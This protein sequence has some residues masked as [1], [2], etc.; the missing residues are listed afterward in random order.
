MTSTCSLLCDDRGLTDSRMGVGI[1]VKRR[2]GHHS[3]RVLQK[4]TTLEGGGRSLGLCSMNLRHL[5]DSYEVSLG[6]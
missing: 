5:Q 1:S 4:N 2:S 6:K 3:S